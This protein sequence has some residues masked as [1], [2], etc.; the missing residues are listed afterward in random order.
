MTGRVGRRPYN[1]V[2]STPLA[3]YV[4]IP[5]CETKCPYCDFN[6]Y[7]AIEPLM[8]SYVDALAH[9][10]AAWGAWLGRPALTSIFFGGG[11]PSYLPPEHLARLT[12]AI[13]AAFAWP[14]GIEAT[15]EA[16]PGDCTPKQ[17]RAM[18]AAGF[19]RLSIGV[20]S[21][22]DGEL[23]LL[24]R[25]HSADDARAAVRGARAAG[26]ANLSIDLMLGLPRQPLDSWARSID[27]AAALDVDHVSV[28]AL[29]LEGGTPMEADVARGALPEPDADLAA[30]M[31]LLAQER[32][33]AAGFEQYEISNWAKP[34]RASR[35][36]LAY[37]E[38][39]PYLG[40]GPGA[41]SHL[42]GDALGPHGVRFANLRSP[43]TYIERVSAWQPAGAVSASALASAGAVETA[44]ALSEATAAGET[45][46]MG[47]RLNEGVS[48]A[49]FR[50]RFGAG[51]AERFPGPVA[52]CLELGLLEWHG[53]RL[54]L[55]EPGR[56]L[57]NEA[58][59]RFV[60]A[61]SEAAGGGGP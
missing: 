57:G 8:P 61:A 40:V 35:H 3:L 21:F 59:G 4:H 43:R 44:E 20:Q 39:R 29:T 32:L 22:D 33:G 37:W 36:N 5:F 51:I 56:L 12:S 53:D 2:V 26:F 17:L 13:G 31:Y 1:G 10:I 16:N 27:E 34:G 38:G 54:R 45:M 55:T 24:G 23:R 11:T 7:A 52:E 60:A 42:L 41:H 50:K 9:E 6:T 28:Y 47:L 49:A 58:F 19:D 15:A 25:R 30:D 18:R 14:D 46:M 48:D